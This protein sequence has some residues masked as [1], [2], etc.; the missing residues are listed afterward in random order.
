MSTLD[1]VVILKL[2]SFNLFFKILKS[3]SMKKMPLLIRQAKNLNTSS[4]LSMIN[5]ISVYAPLIYSI[6][7]KNSDFK[8]E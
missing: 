1:F 4:Y 5:S 8:R 3:Q 2:K 6:F 7:L